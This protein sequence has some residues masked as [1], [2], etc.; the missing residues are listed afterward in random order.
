MWYVSKI[1]RC[2]RRILTAP[3]I[4]YGWLVTL[5]NCITMFIYLAFHSF[6]PVRSAY[7]IVS[8]SHQCV[9][10]GRTC[11][12]NCINIS[13]QYTPIPLP[14][15]LHQPNIDIYLLFW[16]WILLNIALDPSQQ[17]WSLDHMQN[18]HNFLTPL[19]H[20]LYSLIINILMT[21]QISI[22]D[23]DLMTDEV[24]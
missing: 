18:L 11:T 21:V 14:L 19:T 10:K 8:N 7:Q 3:L 17:K 2:R 6:F 9:D 13:L 15:H 4:K 20:P 12:I 22:I 1:E 16:Q 23:K 5:H 24:E